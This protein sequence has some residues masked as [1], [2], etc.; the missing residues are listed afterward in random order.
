LRTTRPIPSRW[1]VLVLIHSGLIQAGVYVV[2]PMTTY[3]AVNLGA[4]ATL[5]GVIGATFALA[6]F[7]L[8]IAVGKWVDFGFAGRA[9]FL[10]P[11]LA[12]VATIGL[13]FADQLWLLLLWMPLLGTGHLLAMVGGQTLIAQFSEDKKYET[14]FGL[15]T[16]YASLGHAIGPFVGGYLAESDGFEITVAPALWFAALLFVLGA[17]ATVPL[18]AKLAA[19]SEGSPSGSI[20]EVFAVPGYKPAIFVAGATTAV[21]DVTLIYLPLLG[22]ALG[23]SVTQ[24]GA[25]LAIRAL[26]SMG[27]RCVLGP[28]RD[29]YGLRAILVVG[30]ALTMLGSIGI[31]VS[32]EFYLIALLL[33]VTGF[34][35]GIGQPAT[36]AWVSRI[37]SPSNR[38][39]AISIRLTSNRLGQ[40]VVPVVAGT[41][42]AV[43]VGGVFYLLAV[44]MALAAG[45]S[46]KWAPGPTS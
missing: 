17:V 32:T 37:S 29:R 22:I 8:A 12:L 20:R 1:L 16:F 19:A 3:Q 35:M 2:R 44:L 4:D 40:V 7:L 36:M 21:V 9:T 23:F 6:P 38:G 5:V 39:L 41:V 31:A 10:G 26:F 34:A 43:S 28:L 33:A 18:F 42:A 24:I 15:L 30:S 45:V 25:L 13:V 11:V 27:V 14:N 46:K